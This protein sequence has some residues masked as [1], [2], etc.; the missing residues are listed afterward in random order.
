MVETEALLR[1]MDILAMASQKDDVTSNVLSYYYVAYARACI[2]KLVALDVYDL[3]KVWTP[4][5]KVDKIPLKKIRKDDLQGGTIILITR[6]EKEFNKYFL[7]PDTDQ[8]MMM[9]FHPVMVW[10][11]FK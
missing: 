11:G 5:T 6:F 8:L 2:S 4:Q 1:Q 3:D 10:T 9:M 7:E